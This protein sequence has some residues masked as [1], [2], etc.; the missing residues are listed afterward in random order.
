MNQQ[1]KEFYAHLNEAVITTNNFDDGSKF[2]KRTKVDQFAYC[3]LNPVYRTYLSF[4][5]DHKASAFRFDE[6]NLPAPTIVTVNRSN[7][8]CH[9]LYRLKTP[10]SYHRNSRN[11][12]QQYFEAVQEAMTVKLDADH[13]FTHTLVK[14][15]LHPRWH[16]M[17]Y[18]TSYDLSD[19]MEYVDLKLPLVK[20]STNHV[21]SR[22]RN[23]SLFHSL[24]FWG[25]AAVHGF[26]NEDCWH[27][28]ILKQAIQVNALF[29]PP[30]P[31]PEL[32]STV[33][34]VGGWI[35]KQRHN[36]GGSRGKV[37]QFTNETPQQRMRLGAEYTN[38]QR[39][40]HVIQKLKTS[41]DSLNLQGKI[42]TPGMLEKQTGLNI[43]T[44]R[45]YL[46]LIKSS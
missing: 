14:N 10:V 36:L 41:F 7:T 11:K 18:A 45:K 33:K 42:I 19:F 38:A 29:T 1:L 26:Q 44:V 12:P 23:D 2:R 25:Y 20:P 43:K 39:S 8:H 24:R 6:V 27:K 22:G 9:Y 28:E 37:L 40:A 34:S 4:D 3:G 13:A 17:T 21:H 16:V 35:W 46:P 30:L 32:K 5:I 15:P 31:F